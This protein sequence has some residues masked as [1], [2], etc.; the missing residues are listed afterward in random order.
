LEATIPGFQIVECQSEGDAE[1]AKIARELGGVVLTGDSDFS[2]LDCPGFVKYV[3]L[4]SCI[5]A[6]RENK[7]Y[8][9]AHLLK[10]G[11]PHKTSNARWPT[12]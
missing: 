4:F 10:F 5:S 12:Y 3:F 1:A 2:I 8:Q 6:T 11:A 7:Q 9:P